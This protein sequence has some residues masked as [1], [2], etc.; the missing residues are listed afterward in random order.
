MLIR[1]LIKTTLWPT[2]GH[3][4]H[5][6]YFILSFFS[7]NATLEQESVYFIL[8]YQMKQNLVFTFLGL[9]DFFICCITI[10]AKICK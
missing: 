1:F 3:T 10:D 2:L 5:N 6:L 9:I 8:K 7:K 4:G